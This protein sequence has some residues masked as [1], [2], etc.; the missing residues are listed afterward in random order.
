VKTIVTQTLNL[1]DKKFN[2]RSVR[3]AIS[4]AKNQKLS[5]DEFEKEQPNYRGG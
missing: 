2:P 1:D 3:Y 5:P 4:N